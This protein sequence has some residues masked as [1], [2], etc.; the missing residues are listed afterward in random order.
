MR[1]DLTRKE[2]IK[3]A[4]GAVMLIFGGVGLLGMAVLYS[5]IVTLIFAFIVLAFALIAFTY[6]VYDCLCMRIENKKRY[7][8]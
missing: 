5:E 7:K 4:I 2:K 6:V 3:C 1:P 8:K